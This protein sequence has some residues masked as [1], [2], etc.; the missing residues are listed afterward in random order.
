MGF[1]DCQDTAGSGCAAIDWTAVERAGVPAGP[2]SVP[3]TAQPR[4][5]RSE[6]TLLPLSF[7]VA[8]V[9]LTCG[10]VRAPA[11]P[12]ERNSYHGP[13]PA[14][15]SAVCSGSVKHRWVESAAPCSR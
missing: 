11:R 1:T 5:I 4:V 14:A 3:H 13:G 15:A 6:K 9:V 7:A 10:Y 12:G 2:A 8:A